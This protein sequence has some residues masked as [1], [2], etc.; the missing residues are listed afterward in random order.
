M[1][2]DH[3]EIILPN[4]TFTLLEPV[5]YFMKN[6]NVQERVSQRL[7]TDVPLLFFRLFWIGWRGQVSYTG[8][9]SLQ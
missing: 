1:N 7:M 3:Y 2:H 5:Q 6:K 9:H 8:I 4:S